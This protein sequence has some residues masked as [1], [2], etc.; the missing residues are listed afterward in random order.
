MSIPG[1]H[2]IYVI[3]GLGIFGAFTIY[4]F[5]RVRHADAGSAIVIAAGIFLDLFAGSRG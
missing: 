4:D 5:N 2:I 1:S 3:A